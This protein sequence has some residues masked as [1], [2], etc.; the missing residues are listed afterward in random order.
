[1]SP[2]EYN[3]RISIVVPY[4]GNDAAFEESLVSVLENRPGDAEICVVHDGSYRD[5][6]DLGDEVR[7]VT[8]AA[9][10]LPSLIAAAEA[11]AQG[12][13]IHLIGDGVRATHGWTQAALQC[14]E[15]PETAV[16]APLVR[17][18]P[19]GPITAAG[20]TDSA[21]AVTSPL[22]AGKT[23]LGRRDAAAV[24]GAYLTASFWRRAELRSVIAAL[25]TDDR[26]AA[27]FAWC[28]LLTAA[29][30]RCVLAD[31]SVVLADSGSLVQPPSL[32]RGLTLRSLAA[33]IDERSLL[34]S[35]AMAVA[36]SLFSPGNWGQAIGQMGSFVKEPAVIRQL[37]FD[38][39]ASPA[40]NAETIRMPSAETGPVTYQRA[41]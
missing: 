8:A 38:Q 10:D 17:T 14:F 22:G 28:R 31:E 19:S 37:R 20:W 3:V 15:N 4:L 32:A 21:T 12:R 33:E 41:A 23:T 1:V 5:P 16:V 30:W 34:A 35:V 13:F 2:R 39:V 11:V 24:R 29:G 9:A 26:I 6:F 7:F 18:S 25:R 36:G 27:E 40:G